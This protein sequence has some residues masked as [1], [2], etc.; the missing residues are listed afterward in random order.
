M[1]RAP[2]QQWVEWLR[3]WYVEYWVIRS[4]ICSFARSAHSFACSA[5][6]AS[7]ARSA[8]LVRS[9]I[10]SLQ[11]SWERGFCLKNGRVD[12][13]PFEPTVV[14]ADHWPTKCHNDDRVAFYEQLSLSISKCADYASNDSCR[15]ICQRVVLKIMNSFIE[16]DSFNS[17]SK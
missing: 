4:S 14:P 3:N 8:A 16:S 9:L 10:Y 6:L 1:A 2:N 7:L 17:V 12:F 13:L 11:S 5:L 15:A